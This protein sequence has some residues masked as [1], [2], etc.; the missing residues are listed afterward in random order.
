MTF[1]DGVA[2]V[3]RRPG[4]YVGPTDDGTGLHNMAFE[5]IGNAINEAL[6]GHAT[7]IA[8]RLS[9]DG[10]CTVQDNGRGIPADP[11]PVYGVSVPEF[12]MTR[13]N[14]TATDPDARFEQRTPVAGLAGVGLC[15]VN[16]L[17]EWLDLTIW[18]DAKEHHIHFRA[19]KA[20]APLKV[21]GDAGGRRGTEVT[22]LPSAKYFTQTRFD[23]AR[24]AT[25]IRELAK[26]YAIPIDFTDAR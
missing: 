16:A 24:L 5:V 2:A 12:I 26:Q 23:Q 14:S 3:Q 20:N 11:H 25:R 19:G 7:A 10:S 18:R 17:S 13:L 6:T 9:S 15:A 4:M 8:V 22:F 1:D 21:M